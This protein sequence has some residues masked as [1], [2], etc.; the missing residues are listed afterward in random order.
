VA[1]GPH[2]IQIALPGYAT[3]ETDIN[4][5][6]RQKVEV[7][8][9]LVKS[10]VPLAEPLLQGETNRPRPASVARDAQAPQR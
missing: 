7:K 6:P 3:F 10:E 5:Q 9:D 8:T 4:A 1:P 2:Q